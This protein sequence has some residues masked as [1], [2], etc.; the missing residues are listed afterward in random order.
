LRPTTPGFVGEKLI[1]AR[2]ARGLN[3]TALADLLQV[4]RQSVSK[5][6]NDQQAP[7]PIVMDE[8]C[9]VL[10]LPID[11]FI[12]KRKREIDLFSPVFYR[13]LS[14]ATKAERLRAEARYI[15][16][17]DIYSYLV[18][19]INFPNLNLPEFNLP[20][21]PS[22]ISNKLIEEIAI[23]LRKFWGLG[24]GP[25]SNMVCLIE[26]NGI[27]IGSYDL[28]SATLE[29]FSQFQFNI[30]H[31][32]LGVDKRSACR[33]RF[34]LGHELGHLI[35]H[36]NV[37]K[38]TLYTPKHFKLIESQAHRF[39]SA[40]LFPEKAFYEEIN[41]PN[42]DFF[43]LKKMTWKISIGAQIFRAQDLGLVSEEEGK[44]LWRSYSRQNMKKQEPL[45]DVME[46]EK[47]TLLRNGFHLIIDSNIKT[48]AS[49]S[50]ELKLNAK[51]IE[52]LSSLE[53]GYLQ[54][55]VIS[56][57]APKEVSPFKSP[58]TERGELVNLF[59]S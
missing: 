31:I 2:L 17:Q 13:S 52:E 58:S 53:M 14:S 24:L 19:F 1:E 42:L 51:D 18:R 36:R 34:S 6:E 57:P 37:S 11:Y 41:Y 15:W 25:I 28:D 46:L 54:N 16:L 4:T 3:A 48:R 21:D 30:P 39:A 56:F 47:P 10:K 27:V 29:A 26:N 12:H 33:N 38:T 49:I 5:Y 32:V 59:K 50:H 9:R 40:F 55:E 8:I 23:E 44:K 45:D 43:R 20:P 7:S 22:L 35:L